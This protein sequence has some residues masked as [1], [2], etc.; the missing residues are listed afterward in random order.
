M[1]KTHRVFY[2]IYK[3]NFHNLVRN[4]LVFTPYKIE[5][6]HLRFDFYTNLFLKRL[7]QVQHKVYEVLRAFEGRSNKEAYRTLLSDVCK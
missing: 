1:C 7:P 5:Q 6:S 2:L 3:I 4:L